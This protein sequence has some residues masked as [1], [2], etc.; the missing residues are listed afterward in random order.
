M[1]YNLINYSYKN[2]KQ[3]NYSKVIH[4]IFTYNFHKI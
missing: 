2:I 3:K 1:K 4:G